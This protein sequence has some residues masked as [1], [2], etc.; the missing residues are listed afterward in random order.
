LPRDIA[1]PSRGDWGTG[2]CPPGCSPGALWARRF[3]G[4]TGILRNGWLPWGNCRGECIPAAS[5]R[6]MSAP[7]PRYLLPP[8]ATMHPAVLL[9]SCLGLLWL[10]LSASTPAFAEPPT[11]PSAPS[12]PYVVFLGTGAA[13]IQRPKN[14]N[15][16]H[17]DALLYV[18]RGKQK[19]LL[20]ATDTGWLPVGT[21]AALSAEKLGLAIVEGAFGEE[22]PTID[23]QRRISDHA[24]RYWR[25]D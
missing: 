4:P 9:R 24:S 18:L 20:Y 5:K 1:V 23:R 15:C 8:H 19:S 21:F 11:T 12:A 25:T 13:D 3:S 16:P 6:E 10:F 14:D 7:P 2:R 22:W 17:E